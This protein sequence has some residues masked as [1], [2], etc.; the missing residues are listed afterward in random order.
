VRHDGSLRYA[1]LRASNSIL[2]WLAAWLADSEL[3]DIELADNDPSP[4]VCPTPPLCVCPIP[5]SPTPTPTPT[6]LLPGPLPAAMA[7]RELMLFIVFM[8][9]GRGSLG[10][11]FVWHIAFEMH[12]QIKLHT[13]EIHTQCISDRFM[14]YIY[15]D[16]SI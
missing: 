15:K 6:L 9:L 10:I 4:P 2:A 5:T 7:L 1:F 16:T 8:A 13:D 11:P 12:R 3:A 14:R